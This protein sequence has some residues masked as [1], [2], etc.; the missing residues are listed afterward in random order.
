MSKPLVV[1]AGWMGCQKRSL[2]RYVK[3]FSEQG[4]QV[5]STV[6]PTHMVVASCFDNSPEPLHYPPASLQE[7]AWETLRDIH[8][9]HCDYYIFY[10]F[11][12]GGC[13]VW[14]QINRILNNTIIVG[15]D[16]SEHHQIVENLKTKAA[17]VIFDSCPSQQ[18]SA[19]SKALAICTW[20]DRLDILQ[21]PDSKGGGW[22]VAFSMIS[23]HKKER[24]DQRSKI[25][26]QGLWNDPWD[27]PQLYLYSQD[28]ILIPPQGIDQLYQHRRQTLG[29]HRIHRCKF[30]SSRHC[31][32]LIDNKEDYITAVQS[33]LEIARNYHHDKS[34]TH[35][36]GS[37][38]S[39]L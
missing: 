6:A 35:P 27:L 5:Y 34:G 20:R 19:V 29:A 12:N 3:F 11:S 13:F 24:A 33:F 16:T 39:K 25:Y 15:S 17:G 1:L 28:D 2:N 7:F 36:R 32:H 37:P 38:Y 22:D 4:Y 14:E 21:M 26:Y 10:A 31:A 18:L 30:E 9:C 23:A 8:H